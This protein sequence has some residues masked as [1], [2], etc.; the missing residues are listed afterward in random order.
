MTYYGVSVTDEKLFE[1][2]RAGI[3]LAAEY[4]TGGSDDEWLTCYFENWLH[5]TPI[6]GFCPIY[7]DPE[8]PAPGKVTRAVRRLAPCARPEG[9][10]GKHSWDTGKRKK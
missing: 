5:G 6:P 9:H 8:T 2:F 1:A 4:V 3:D 10:E 7:P